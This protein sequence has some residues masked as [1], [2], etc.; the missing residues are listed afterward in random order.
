MAHGRNGRYDVLIGLRFF[1]FFFPPPPMMRERW[2]KR[3]QIISQELFFSPPFP[4]LPFL[5][6]LARKNGG[7]FPLFLFFL[8]SDIRKR[9]QDLHVATAPRQ[10]L[11]LSLQE[12]AT[13]K[14]GVK[15][16]SCQSD[17]PPFS[18][19]PFFFFFLQRSRSRHGAS[20]T[21]SEIG[22]SPPS[23]SGFLHSLNSS[24]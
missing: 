20:A 22:P 1:F 3:C 24:E 21:R 9:G 16:E 2:R 23:P 8:F 13:R 11:C 17:L 14:L 7:F 18:F 19:F 10:Y 15:G 5:Q 4:W 12:R 6:E